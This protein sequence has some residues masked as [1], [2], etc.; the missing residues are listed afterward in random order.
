MLSTNQIYLI[1]N[2]TESSN[3]EDSYRDC[4]QTAKAILIL[5]R[6][7]EPDEAEDVRRSAALTAAK[8]VA[9]GRPKLVRHFR[10]RGLAS[11][12]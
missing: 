2:V 1:M 5:S 7:H 6:L 11:I 9:E 12:L 10:Y 3:D 4:K 8:G